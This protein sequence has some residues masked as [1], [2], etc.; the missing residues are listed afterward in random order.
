[1]P[2]YSLVPVDHQPD[3]DDYSLAPVDYDPFA[4]DGLAR[5]AQFQQPPTPT[6]PAQPQPQQP[7]TG[8]GQ[9]DAGAPAAGGGPS[10]S[11]GGAGVGNAGSDPSNPTWAQGR[12]SQSANFDGYFNP[13]PTASPVNQAKTDDQ[14]ALTR[15]KIVEAA[16]KQIG[17]GDWHFK[18]AKGNFGRNTYKCNLFVY[19]ML[20]D[21]GA[22]P[23][24]PKGHWW[25]SYPPLAAN[26]ADPSFAIPGWRVLSSGES[27]Q[28][29]N[30]VGQRI[31]WPNGA[32]GH[33]MIVGPNAS[34]IGVGE[35]EK[36]ENVAAKMMGKDKPGGLLVYRRYGP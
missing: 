27:P 33:V 30:V 2:D 17:S 29:G 24:L 6:Q 16:Q 4:E 9:P 21:A 25:K 26:W 14:L 13:T 20:T 10:G 28:P 12:S 34:F 23:G 3:F 36:I 19:D 22:S 8:A 11:G 1:M 32:T 5:Q 7:A 31:Q 15:Q 35:S 18:V